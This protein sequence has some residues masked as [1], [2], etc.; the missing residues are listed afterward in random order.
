MTRSA[1]RVL[2]DGSAGALV[3]VIRDVA[4]HHDLILGLGDLALRAADIPGVRVVAL[5][6]LDE[7]SVP[8]VA[9]LSDH[10]VAPTDLVSRLRTAPVVA[11]A[12]SRR[13]VIKDLSPSSSRWPGVAVDALLAG[14]Y[15]GIAVVPSAL[16]NSIGGALLAMLDADPGESGFDALAVLAD[17]LPIIIHQADPEPDQV[18]RVRTLRRALDDRN[19]IE[20]AKG[21][22]AKRFDVTPDVAWVRLRRRA[23]VL[24]CTI[25]EAAAAVVTGTDVESAGGDD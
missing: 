20:Q 6:V 8:Q 15:M 22:L 12:C 9:G 23:E 13:E 2:G 17:L 25:A 14:G 5:L 3:D 10:A 24:G 7:S 21:M 18:A 1:H 11:E 19:T 16:P 4:R